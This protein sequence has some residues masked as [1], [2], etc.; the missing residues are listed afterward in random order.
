L[1]D[2]GHSFEDIV[3]RVRRHRAHEY[4]LRTAIPLK[5]VSTL[6]GYTEQSTF[7]RACRRWFGR[8]PLALRETH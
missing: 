3:D 6:L 8:S 2:A 1:R 4:L 5:Q 7:I